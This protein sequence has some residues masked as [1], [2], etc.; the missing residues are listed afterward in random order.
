[1]ISMNEHE[2]KWLQT[3]RVMVS[4]YRDKHPDDKRSDLELVES[5]MEHFYE[6][7]LVKKGADGKWLLPDI[8]GPIPLIN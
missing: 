8:D 2:R 3:L 5:L 6:S 4:D 7:G 1:M